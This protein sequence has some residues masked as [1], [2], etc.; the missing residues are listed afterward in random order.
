MWY[1]PRGY[2]SNFLDDLSLAEY[3]LVKLVG[4]MFIALGVV[5]PNAFCRVTKPADGGE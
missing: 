4:R 2:V 3:D 1:H 5:A